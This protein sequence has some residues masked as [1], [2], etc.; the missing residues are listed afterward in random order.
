M[1]AASA[2][3]EALQGQVAEL[4]ARVLPPSVPWSEAASEGALWGT[5]AGLVL[6]AA[7]ILAACPPLAAVT[8][9]VGAAAVNKKN[10]QR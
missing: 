3:V 4:S 5:R 2:Q 7:N 9:V 6:A 8:M 1:A 10:R